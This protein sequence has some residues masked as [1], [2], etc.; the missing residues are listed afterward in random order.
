MRLVALTLLLIV[1]L[2]VGA[3]STLA[4][5]P[6][7][8]EASGPPLGKLGKGMEP[9][10]GTWV[11]DDGKMELTLGTSGT[12]GKRFQIT[13][14]AHM[15]LHGRAI[16]E[17]GVLKVWISGRDGTSTDEFKLKQDGDVLHLT[18]SEGKTVRYRRTKKPE[19]DLEKE[20]DEEDLPPREELIVGEWEVDAEDATWWFSFSKAGQF[21]SKYVVK[22]TGVG[23]GKV[24]TWKLDG[25]AIVFHYTKSGNYLRQGFLVTHRD[26]IEIIDS[27]GDVLRLYRKGADL[28]PGGPAALPGTWTAKQDGATVKMLLRPDGTMVHEQHGAEGSGHMWGRY[29]VAGGTLRLYLDRQ[30]EKRFGFKMPDDDTLVLAPGTANEVTMVRVDPAP[31]PTPAPKGIVG[32]WVAE[33]E[34]VRY[35]VALN[36][37]GS[38]TNTMTSKTTGGAPTVIRGAYEF[39]GGT[40]VARPQGDA[41]LHFKARLLGANQLELVEPSGEITVLQRTGTEEEAAPGPKPL[42]PGRLAGRWLVRTGNLEILIVFQADGRYEETT[43]TAQGSQTVKGRYERYEG[44][45]RVY[46]DQGEARQLRIRLIDDAT[47]KITDDGGNGVQLKRQS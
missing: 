12:Y 30:G 20:A 38:F 25:D 34:E 36:A 10:A 9:L 23:G 1:A 32:V 27:K 39:G 28:S 26:A 42:P 46:P 7:T 3:G 13:P 6:A 16:C 31:K 43:K 14:E 29:R 8:A 19:E 41:P 2:L 15:D 11:S 44:M 17:D 45:I 33:D 35:E 5:P 21:V 4:D 40:L 18:D 22:K 37:D 24:G 47:L